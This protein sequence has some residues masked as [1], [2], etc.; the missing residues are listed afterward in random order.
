[1]L[2]I[3]DL[4]PQAEATRPSSVNP[5]PPHAHAHAGAMEGAEQQHV[6]TGSSPVPT[7][8]AAMTSTT[9]TTTHITTSDTTTEAMG[10]LPTPVG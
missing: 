5:P 4:Q 7:V 1:M 10:V 6:P 3:S 8:G 2:L 9:T